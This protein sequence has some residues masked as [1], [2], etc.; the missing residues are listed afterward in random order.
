M[1]KNETLYFTERLDLSINY[2]HADL[3]SFGVGCTKL[4]LRVVVLKHGYI[5]KRFTIIVLSRKNS[6]SS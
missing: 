4:I 1:M 3:S 6:H 5:L 2:F